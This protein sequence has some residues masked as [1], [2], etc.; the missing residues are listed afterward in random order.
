M[1]EPH[2]KEEHRPAEESKEE[3]QPAKETEEH[4]EK[5]KMSRFKAAKEKIKETFRR[6]KSHEKKEEGT[7]PIEA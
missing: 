4:K 6:G 1:V 5:K 7:K 3:Q 2:E